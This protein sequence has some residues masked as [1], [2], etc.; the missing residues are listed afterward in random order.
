LQQVNLAFTHDSR[1]LQL[2]WVAWP[3]GRGANLISWTHS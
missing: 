1:E 2:Y 3:R